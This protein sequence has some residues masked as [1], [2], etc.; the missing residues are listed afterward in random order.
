MLGDGCIYKG[1]SGGLSRQ[2]ST[3]S[4]RLADD[5]QRLLLHCGYC[6]DITISNTIGR[7]N[8]NGPK[9]RSV[10]TKH[11][12]YKLGIKE[13]AVEQQPKGGYKPILMPYIGEVFC[14]T[15]GNGLIYVRRNGRVMWMGNSNWIEGPNRFEAPQG[16][17]WADASVI[18]RMCKQQ[19][20]VALSC[21]AGYP[22]QQLV[23]W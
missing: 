7:V 3:T 10:T 1:G 13:I 23:L 16:S 6:G 4:K 2:Y 19:D 22:R 18:D 15:T 12:N 9:G 8:R 21:Y 5:F 11:I 14:V 17:F 20:T